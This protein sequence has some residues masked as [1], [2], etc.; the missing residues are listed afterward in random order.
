MESRWSE[1]EAAGQ[2]DLEGLLYASRLVG[3]DQSLVLWGGGNTSAKVQE[4]DF[5][6]RPVS[7][8]RVKGSGSDL[9]TIRVQDFPGVR[10]E[11]VLPLLQREAMADEEMVAYLAHTL[12]EPA[13]PRPSIETLL[14]AFLPP[15]FVVHTHADAILSLT[16][17]VSGRRQ[18]ADAL[19]GDVIWVG[20][21]RPGF[22]LSKE[23]AEAFRGSPMATAIVLEKHGLITWGDTAR[24]AY[25]ATAETVTRAQQAIAKGGA[26]G[27]GARLRNPPDEVSRWRA[28][29]AAPRGGRA[30][31][32]HSGPL[33]PGPGRAYPPG[34]KRPARFADPGSAS[35]R[36]HRPAL[37]RS[38]GHPGLRHRPP[39]S[40]PLSDRP[41]HPRPPDQHP[42]H[43]A[44][45]PGPG[46]RYRRRG[47]T[48]GALPGG[49]GAGLA[50]LGGGLRGLRPRR[51]W[52]G[53]RHGPGA[54]R[55]PAPGGLIAGGGD[56]HPGPG[57]AGRRG[58]GGY[59]PPRHRDP[60]RRRGP[61]RLRL[62]GRA[63]LLRRGVLAPGA[64]Q[65][66]PGPPGGGALAQ[67]GAGHRSRKRNW[68]GHRRASLRR[69]GQRGGQRPQRRRGRRGG[70]C[71]EREAGRRAGD[72]GR[73]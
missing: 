22:A 49:P 59:L 15:R 68:A 61:G 70:H 2:P 41:G 53:R 29:G 17:T 50:G 27:G 62:P 57:H 44:L 71:P 42:P 45:R 64:V 12:M 58:G 6:G 11:D 73:D 43:A 40:A 1:A 48:A 46:G 25:E 3:A 13:S 36:A 55:S 21:R 51:G 19:G 60:A 23:V 9:R 65:A 47:G 28:G 33:D 35:H 52:E 56:G 72:S 8:L 31:V 24:A 34:W 16:N 63:G 39:G 10:L 14:H 67:G 5:R 32:P 26:K 66:D 7:V 38:G 69:R 18:V 4:T 20:Y 30:G 37:R 54:A